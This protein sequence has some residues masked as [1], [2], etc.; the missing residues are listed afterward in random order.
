[1]EKQT[2]QPLN[3]YNNEPEREEF[4]TAV[5]AG[6]RQ[7][8]KELPCKYL[9]DERGSLLFDKICEL[10]EY[11][12]TRTE[13]NIMQQ[14]VYEIAGRIG[15]GVQLIEYGSGSS[16]KTRVLLDN[17]SDLAGYIPIDI[18]KEHLLNAARKLEK[19]YPDLKVQ[20]VCADY[21][22]DF[23]LPDDI[24]PTAP[25]A[26]YF[27]GSTIGNFNPEDALDFLKS[28]NRVIDNNGVL[29]LGVDLKKDP[30]ILHRAY[31]DRDGITAAFN[32]NILTRMNR[33]LGAN[34]NTDQFQHYAFFNPLQGRIEM[35]IISLENQSVRLNGTTIH[36][37]KGES[38]HTENSYKYTLKEFA[39]LAEKA[40]FTVDRVW[41]D[42][43]TLF[44]V[45][46]LRPD[47]YRS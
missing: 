14:Y 44:S 28:I 42:D 12:P 27:P 23:T 26:V 39:G 6:L 38:I 35:H 19:I 45:Q 7:S 37:A 46:L 40:G 47:G 4:M 29:F 17:L 31:N 30:V 9:Y 24:H 8:G 1:M 34:F 3:F 33:E 16:L 10:D 25:R 21:T 32:C 43:D 5:I 41:T 2:A 18:S 15:R 20:P 36:F 11:Y 22:K 13:L